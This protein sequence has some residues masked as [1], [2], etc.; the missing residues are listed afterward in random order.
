M[1]SPVNSLSDLVLSPGLLEFDAQIGPKSHRLWIKGEGGEAG[2]VTPHADSALALGLVPAMTEGGVLRVEGEVSPRVLRMQREFQGIERAWSLGWNSGAPPLEEVAVEAGMRTI[3]APDRNDRV[4][5]FFS[6][7][8]DSWATL[9]SEPE[10]T[11]LIFVKGVD[12]LPSLTPLHVG[13]GERV[14]AALG[15]VAAEMGKRL[16][17]V[18]VNIREFSEPLIEWGFFFN[19]T[20]SAIAL[21]FEPLFDRVLIP[22]DTNHLNQPPY[23]SSRMIDGL[24]SSEAIEIVDHGGRLTRIERIRLIA[25]NPLVQRSLRVCYMNHDRLYNC[26]RCPKCNYTMICLEALGMRAK[27][28]TFP[29]E[30]DFTVL[31]D[32]VPAEQIH[33][34]LWEEALQ[35]VEECAREDLAAVVRPLVERGRRNLTDPALIA[36]AEEASAA[37]EEAAAVRAQLNEVLGSTSWR[38][39]EPLRRAGIIAR[40]ARTRLRG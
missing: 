16:H 39:T 29:D 30:F 35:L 17:V 8:V 25:Q 31:E 2:A 1:P 33:L 32:Y 13:L 38:A 18:E 20:L 23:G 21:Y 7:G 40:K 26:G 37:Q 10:I 27:F 22:S 14:E 15:E 28:T 5:A 19:S 36:A 3:P 34:V 24:W 6:G 4:A 11:D 12:I 9:L